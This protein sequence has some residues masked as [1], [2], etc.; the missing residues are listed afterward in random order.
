MEN[1]VQVCLI[2]LLYLEGHRAWKLAR[3]KQ[4]EADRKWWTSQRT[5]GICQ[6][7]RQQAEAYDL[8]K[9]EIWSRTRGGRKKLRKILRAARPLEYRGAA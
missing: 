4:S 1:W 6:A 5:Y 8:D 3:R 7:V 2:T 9:L